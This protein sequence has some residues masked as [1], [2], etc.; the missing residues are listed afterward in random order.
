MKRQK[1]DID[2]LVIGPCSLEEKDFDKLK[3]AIKKLGLPKIPI[4]CHHRIRGLY[5]VLQGA[6][7]IHACNELDIREIDV[8]LKE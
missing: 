5:R 1:V 4:V 7:I 3:T 2:D 8:D 6:D